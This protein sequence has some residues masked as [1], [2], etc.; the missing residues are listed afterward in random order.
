VLSHIS[1]DKTASILVAGSAENVVMEEL[2]WLH[3]TCVVGAFIY[4]LLVCK[5]SLRQ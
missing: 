4:Y 3:S 2:K 1:R 5:F